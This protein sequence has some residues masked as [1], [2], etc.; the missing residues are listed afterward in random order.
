MRR[1]VTNKIRIL[2]VSHQKDVRQSLGSLL[3]A[4]DGFSVVA[5]AADHR[6]AIRLASRLDMDVVLMDS[7]VSEAD[8]WEVP[9]RIKE[10]SPAVGI[11]MFRWLGS[12][13]SEPSAVVT[14]VDAFVEKRITAENLAEIIRRVHWRKEKD[15]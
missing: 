15:T 1:Q 14:G 3:H 4:L 12:E 5:E 9:R 7:S 11:V 8:A 13:N 10:A 2:I 6:E